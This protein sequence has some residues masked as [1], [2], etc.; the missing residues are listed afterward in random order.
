MGKTSFNTT[1]ELIKSLSETI[2]NLN[3]GKL[4][5]SD[6]DLLVR[7]SQDLYEQLIILRYKAYDTLG[8]PIH[9]K[10]EEQSIIIQPDPP[11]N[12]PQ[13][14]EEIPFDFS[15]ITSTPQ[16]E[17]KDEPEFVAPKVEESSPAAEPSPI[18][19]TSPS[20]QDEEEEEDE[21]E[22]NSLNDAFK[23]G[24]DQSLRK[25]FQNSPISDIKSQI[26]IGKKFE[27]I[28]S[29]FKGNAAAYEDAI[30]F[31]NTAANGNEAKLKLN[32][33][34]HQYEWDLEDKSIAKFIEL[35]ERRY[36]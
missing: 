31:L 34:T 23:K 13:A 25:L 27:Y 26:S 22:V 30:D 15:G 17:V 21:N 35:V 33:L 8:E 5:L 32:D 2:N 10:V 36:L 1:S 12:E 7:D 14:I 9:Q 3:S 20:S 29:M 6:L 24:E 11:K 18:H 28:S 16:Q 4:S 19:K